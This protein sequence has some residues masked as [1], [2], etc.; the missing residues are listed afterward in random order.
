MQPPSAADDGARLDVM[1]LYTDGMAAAHPG[2]QIDTRIQ[3]LIDVGNDAFANSN[4]D[5]EINLV[6]SAQ[7]T[8]PDDSAS[9]NEALYDLT[10]NEGVFTNV[11]N[12]RT[13]YGADQVTLLRRYVDEGCGLAWVHTSS[14]PALAYAVV[15]DGSKPGGWYCSDRTY[16]HEFGHNLGCAHDIGNSSVP[17]WFSYSYGYQNQAG[18]FYTVMAYSSGCSGCTGI[19]YFSNPDI[20]YNSF[21]TGTAGADNARTINFTRTVMA[22]YRSE[23]QGSVTVTAPNGSENWEKYS[24]YSITWNS[25]N[26]S[27]EDNVKIDLYKGG[28]FSAAIAASTPNDGS[29]SWS[30][31]LALTADTDYR[32]RISSVEDAG[33]YDES[34]GDFTISDPNDFIEVTRPDSAITWRKKLTYEIRWVSSGI[35]GNV[36][37]ELLK[38]GALNATIA[39]STSNDGSHPWTIPE[40]QADGSDYSVKITSVEN[41][42]IWDESDED[43]SIAVLKGMSWLK[44]LLFDN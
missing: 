34:D 32:I 18:L 15:H 19:S 27:V 14:R 44:I 43:F 29:Y 16:V 30:V 24:S 22:Q 41:D 31:P 21:A 23:V 36:R 4:I 12:L 2:A 25:F 28:E 5:T 38:G 13:T 9:M 8:Y 7:V 6:Y 3:Y 33:I 11:E 20:T 26:L 1:I 39:A 40:S 10:D 35:T 17:G 37:I 42:T